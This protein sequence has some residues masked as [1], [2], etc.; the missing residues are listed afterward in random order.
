MPQNNRINIS[1][2]NALIALLIAFIVTLILA[3]IYALMALF[4]Y[5]NS[6]NTINVANVINYFGKIFWQMIKQV[7]FCALPIIFILSFALLQRFRIK[8]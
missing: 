5:V 1:G 6:D 4:I 2:K 7:G 3:G 8:D